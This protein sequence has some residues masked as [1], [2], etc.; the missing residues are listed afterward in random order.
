MW[1]QLLPGPLAGIGRVDGGRFAPPFYRRTLT[2][3]ALARRPATS[4]S[5]SGS[6]PIASMAVNNGVDPMFP[7][8]G[9]RSPC[10]ARGRASARLAPVKR[11]DELIEL[12]SP[13]ARRRVP[14]LQLAIVGDGPCEPALEAASPRTAPTDWVRFAGHVP[15]PSS[16]PSTSGRGWSA[17]PRWPRV[18]A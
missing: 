5:L 4:C 11:Y 6:D 1:D 13:V 17:A 10:A 8:G 18:G 14:D 16:S 9:A 7:P 2:R 15:T 3:D 12:R